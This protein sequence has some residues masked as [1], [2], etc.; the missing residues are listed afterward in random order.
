MIIGDKLT[1]ATARIPRPA[2]WF[3]GWRRWRVLNRQVR[4]LLSTVDRQATILEIGGGYN[5]RFTKA[6][7]PRT[8]HLDHCSAED[9]RLKYATVPQ[10]AHLLHRIQAI[11]FV[12]TG[13]PIEDLIPASLRFDL[14]YGSHVIEHQ[15]DLIAHLQS[16]ERLLAPGGRVIQIVPDFRCCFDALRYPSLCSDALM[17]H[18][19]P[20]RVHHGK[21][22]FDAL[23]RG[24][25]CNPGRSLRRK[26]WQQLRFNTSL[27]QAM[28][29]TLAAE[30]DDAPYQDLHAWAFC[31]ES[32]LLMLVELRLLGLTTLRATLVTPTYGNQFCAVLERA[33]GPVAELPAAVQEGLEDERRTLMRALRF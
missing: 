22:V 18:L 1:R 24:V 2:S 28:A 6:E 5:P 14:I 30:Q 21:Q 8:Y 29:A 11:D 10:V 12:S 27:S 23:S 4:P 25:D 32:L 33:K 20:G 9:L 13:A 7:Y 17:A 31:P 16:L 15:V 26:D 3:T 19:R